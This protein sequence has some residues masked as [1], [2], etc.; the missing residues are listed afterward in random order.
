M[1]A[2][3]HKNIVIVGLLIL[4]AA[5][6]GWFLASSRTPQQVVVDPQASATPQRA[7]TAARSASYSPVEIAEMEQVPETSKDYPRAQR[8]LGYNVW[9]VDRG[10]WTE[11]KRHV[12]L[13]LKASPDD[14]K[15]LEDAGRVYLKVGLTTEGQEML[16]RAN[17]PVAL[18]ALAKRN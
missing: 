11:A 6:W 8:L 10:N 17:T 16:K 15:V 5:S 9:G 13:A 18:H 4:L 1:N 2:S 14:P 12:D 7:S 3:M